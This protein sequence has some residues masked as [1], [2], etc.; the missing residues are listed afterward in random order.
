MSTEETA[1][2]G[3]PSE[4][5]VERLIDFERAVVITPMIYPPRPRLVVDGV[6]NIPVDVTL[7]PLVYVSQPTY[8]GIQVVASPGDRDGPRPSQPIAAIPY[9]VELDLAGVTGTD[10]VEVIGATMTERLDIPAEVPTEVPT[11]TAQ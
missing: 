4:E 7:V 2:P 3:V 9:H 8:W 1:P 5:P 11:E 10:G 6:T